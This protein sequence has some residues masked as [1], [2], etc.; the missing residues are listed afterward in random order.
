[1]V[2]GQRSERKRRWNMRRLRWKRKGNVIGD[3]DDVGDNE[4]KTIMEK[5]ERRKAGDNVDDDVNNMMVE[6]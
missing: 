2:V 5:K 6:I 3:D 1:M 4:R